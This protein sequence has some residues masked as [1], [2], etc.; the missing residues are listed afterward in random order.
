MLPG[1]PLL[2]GKIVTNKQWW[3]KIVQRNAVGQLSLK[4][5]WRTKMFGYFQN[6]PFQPQ[7][8][9]RG[10]RVRLMFCFSSVCVYEHF[11][12]YIVVD[13]NIAQLRTQWGGSESPN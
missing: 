5:V 11:R 12:I 7:T 2:C 6:T 1:P 3:P 8:A 10:K 4:N 13:T 9:S